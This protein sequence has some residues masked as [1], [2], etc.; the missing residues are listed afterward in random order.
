LPATK[1]RWPAA[2]TASRRPGWASR[3]HARHDRADGDPSIGRPSA[4]L[5]AAPIGDVFKRTIL[6][7]HDRDAAKRSA[8]ARYLAYASDEAARTGRVVSADDPP[9][10][11]AWLLPRGP[12]VDARQ[13][14]AKHA[15]LA[16]LCRPHGYG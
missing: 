15:F 12:E 7:A 11:G 2:R 9:S 16:E 4:G 5:V 13:Q 1:R 6:A 10:R 3:P 14:A 8:L